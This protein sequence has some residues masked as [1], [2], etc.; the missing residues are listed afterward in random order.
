[1]ANGKLLKI[2]QWETNYMRIVCVCVCVCIAYT[3]NGGLDHPAFVHLGSQV[4]RLDPTS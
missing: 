3:T 4:W 2:V 1:M